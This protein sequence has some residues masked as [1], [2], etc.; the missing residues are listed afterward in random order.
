MISLGIRAWLNPALLSKAYTKYA[1][2]E[3]RLISSKNRTNYL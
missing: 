1:E 2:I 3:L